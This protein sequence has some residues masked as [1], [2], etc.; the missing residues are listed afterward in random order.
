[1]LKKLNELLPGERGIIIRITG[2]PFMKQRLLEMGLRE[3]KEVIRRIDAP[4]GDPI[5]IS[6]MGINLSL[7]RQIANHIW[8]ELEEKIDKKEVV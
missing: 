6:I 1:M 4:L 8:V 3:G 7:R 5:S 2:N